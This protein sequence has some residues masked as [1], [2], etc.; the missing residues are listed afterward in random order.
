MKDIDTFS[1][2]T[3]SPSSL[4]QIIDVEMQ[5]LHTRQRTIDYIYA[6]LFWGVIIIAA[7]IVF[8]LVSEPL[9]VLSLVVVLITFLSA[10]SF[11]HVGAYFRTI[12]WALRE[13]DLLFEKGFFWKSKIAVPFNRIQHAEV[14]QNPIQRRYDLA[15]LKI[16]T[17]GGASSDVTIYGIKEPLANDIKSF[18]LNRVTA[19]EEQ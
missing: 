3:V 13:H 18:I 14:H 4:P 12:R 11:W 15:S 5:P 8:V 10:F 9:W 2:N 17:A 6:A 7:T 19:D 16:Y 1:N